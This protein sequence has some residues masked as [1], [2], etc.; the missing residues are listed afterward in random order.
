MIAYRF[1]NFCFPYPYYSKDNLQ[2]FMIA[3]TLVC[4]IMNQIYPQLRYLVLTLTSFSR[5]QN[6][7]A[8]ALP[9][10]HQK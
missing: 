8:L 10:F 2:W 5:C 7:T 6:Q 4:E 3:F 9:A 1:K